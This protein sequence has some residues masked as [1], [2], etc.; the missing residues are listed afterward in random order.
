VILIQLEV[1]V[2]LALQLVFALN[3]KILM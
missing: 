3:A 1:I 2:K